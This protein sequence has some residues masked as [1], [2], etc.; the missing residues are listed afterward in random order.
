MNLESRVRR[1]NSQSNTTELISPAKCGWVTKLLRVFVLLGAL[2]FDL[3]RAIAGSPPVIPAA[4]QARMAFLV[5]NGY[6]VGIVAGLVT[7]NGVT[8]FSYGRKSLDSDDRVDEDSLFEVGSV[9]KTFTS[10]V[11][12]EL[13]LAGD[14]VLT[15]AIQPYLP[16]TVHVPARNGKAI[17]FQ[18]L[19]THTSGLPDVPSN[20]TNTFFNLYAT[21]STNSLY[22]FLNSYSLTRDPGAKFEYS[23]LG[24]GILGH[25]LARHLGQDYESIIRERITGPLGMADTV[26]TLD[27]GQQ[28]RLAKPF[29]GV[30]PVSNWD[31]SEVFVG[32]GSI[33]STARDMVRYISANM[34]LYPSSIDRA[35]TNA[36]RL[37]YSAADG[38]FGLAWFLDFVRSDGLG[39]IYHTGGTAGYNVAIGWVP[40]RH[41]GAVVLCNTD[42]LTTTSVDL[43]A[44]L[45]D[46]GYT[47]PTLATPARQPLS[48]LQQKVGWYTGNSGVGDS[49]HIVLTN[50]HLA[51]VYSGDGGWGTT[52]YPRTTNSFY[53]VDIPASCRFNMD[54]NGLTPSLVWNQGSP[55]TYTRRREVSSL[56]IATSGQQ[57]Q[58]S[59]SG[60]AD[61]KFEV[62][63]SSDLFHWVNLSTNSIWDSPIVVPIA[64][65]EPSRFFRL[66]NQ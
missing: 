17:S 13:E 33:R 12:S 36:H 60:D 27:A 37:R 22:A 64:T 58:L 49:F 56:S 30:Y 21:Y 4:V 54:T 34:G 7:S 19:A 10:T 43:W 45:I 63:G 14:L 3:R 39:T 9:T 65:G 6:C 44:R 66:V 16:T 32:M 61:R 42:G 20:L 57:L 46:P 23:N 38:R 55:A 5:T 35:L 62:Q 8:F 59:L 50:D 1:A 24:V 53:S 28:R 2:S 25:I 18:H 31:F 29:G 48:S 26:I 15:N 11:L 40:A 52:L 41:E 51:E 47:W